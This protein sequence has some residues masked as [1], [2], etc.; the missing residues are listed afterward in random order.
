M[1]AQ[2]EKRRV[3]NDMRGS[4]GVQQGAQTPPP[5][6]MENY[7]AIGFHSNICPDPLKNHKTTKQAFNV[8]PSLGR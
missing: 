1:T 4:K 7:K 2:G 6:P 3:S 8:G 5:T